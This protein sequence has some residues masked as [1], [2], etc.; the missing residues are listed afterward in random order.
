MTNDANFKPSL[1]VDKFIPE[2]PG[3]D[4]E[5]FLIFLRAYYEWLQTTTITLTGIS[6]TFVRD[7]AVTSAG[8]GI[9]IIKE[10]ESGYIIIK[11]TSR[12]PFNRAEI[13]TGG[14]SNATATIS[15]IK[16][17]VI[18]ASGNLQNYKNFEF[19]IDKYFE[20]LQDEL[21]PS[22]PATI[23]GDK[24]LLATKF[25]QF[26]ESRSNEE[27]YRFLFKLLYNENV[28][29]Y[30]PGEDILRV[31]DGN[32]DKPQILRAVVTSNIFNFLNKTIR[33]RTS[34]ALANV[35]DIKIFNLGSTEVAEMTLK[36]V[37][38]TFLGN[39]Q[40]INIDNE[41]LTSNTYGMITG[42]TINDAGSGYEVDN[43]III[44][45]DGSQAKVFVSSISDAPISALK[46]NEIG[47]GYQLNANAII[48]NTGTGGSGL[49]VRVTELANTYTV[50]SG[51]NTYTVGE[52]AT[53]S[54]INRGTEY[55]KAPTVTLEDTTISGLGLLSA[56]LITIANSGIDYGVGN[57]LVFTGGSGANA[58]G[59]V[60]SVEESVTYDFLF[61]DEFRMLSEDSYDDII[62]NEDW[63]VSGSIVRIELT[64]FGDGYE[65]ANLPIITVTS[66]TGSGANLV[67]TNIQGKSAN[68]S[69]DIANN[70]VG[71]GAI[72]AVEI[73]NFGV[74]YTTANADL[75]AIGD[76]N[77]NLTP[78]I[79]GLGIGDG[80]FVNDD[81]KIDFK[82]IQDSFFYQDF[83]YVI[84]SGLAF[85][86][87]KDA[88]KKIIHP[89]GLQ[90]F[91]EILL[92]NLVDISPDF[93]VTITT[94]QNTVQEILDFIVDI[95][96]LTNVSTSVVEN[97]EIDITPEA[98]AHSFISNNQY[99]I[100]PQPDASNVTIQ[101]TSAE[102]EIEFEIL[103]DHETTIANNEYLL[104]II[105]TGNTSI[106]Y[107][108]G[109]PGITYGNL[110]ISLLESNTILEFGNISFDTVF[111]LESSVIKNIKISG[112]VTITSLDVVGIGTSFTT[113]FVP[114]DFLIINNSEKFI[115]N[116]ISNNTFMTIN[117]PP[118][119]SYIGAN[120]FKEVR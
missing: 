12:L 45:G 55:I 82:F 60:A 52:I 74:N 104:K 86:V 37:S 40:I 73:R 66:T 10:V 97:L 59:Q 48:S 31:S 115:I 89:A 3:L 84:K 103:T 118:V 98:N 102:R 72:R 77:A 81:G 95:F 29:F 33:G 112:N 27:S 17:N 54:I 80:A 87:Y 8:G 117:V 65:S 105:E 21:Y 62:K 16:D 13:I 85:N 2:D 92:S 38:G 91:G 106:D 88:I 79:S 64:N 76:G 41:T 43:E 20:Y 116:S 67:A 75:T 83:S 101:S 18:R 49:A 51:N 58:A 32:F 69:V 42:F 47:H 57:T 26:F 70:A 61:E 90:P 108:V 119:G 113:D 63:E 100:S 94:Q 11:M 96:S 99:V 23:Y 24:R 93:V 50:I 120:A 30:Y 4:S 36:L 53:V 107:E 22:L 25:K 28:E 19:S 71:I 39:E 111:S 35:V 1:H 78:I 44:A 5:R 15:A 7:E 6:G 110:T 68:I 109:Y 46:T 9:G 56:K 14:T 114:N 34:G